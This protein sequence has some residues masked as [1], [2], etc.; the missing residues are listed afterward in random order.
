MTKIDVLKTILVQQYK[1]AQFLQLD[2]MD[3]MRLK[4]TRRNALSVKNV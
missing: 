2:N 3:L 1:F 4:L